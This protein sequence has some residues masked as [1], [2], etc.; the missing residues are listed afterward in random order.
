LNI[1]KLISSRFDSAG[2]RFVKV[3][4][5]GKEDTREG[6][7]VAP[8][9][10]DSNPVNY[11]GMRAIFCETG[12]KGKQIILGYI[13]PNQ[14]AQI[15]EKRIFSTDKNGNVKFYIWLHSDGTCDFGGN[16]NHLTQFEALKTAFDEL[17]ADFNALVA[18]YNIHVHP[19][20]S[21]GAGTSGSTP[22]TGVQSN[23]D[24]SGAKLNNLKTQ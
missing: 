1:T 18:Q 2:R 21:T 14:L 12:V 6:Y 4:R 23:A 16:T 17:K 3:L 15:G 10:D 11:E 7:Q 13:H 22:N 24:M 5:T 19:G 9:G 8:F 20:V